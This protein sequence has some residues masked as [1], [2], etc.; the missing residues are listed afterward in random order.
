MNTIRMTGERL[1]SKIRDDLPSWVPRAAFDTYLRRH[2]GK[3]LMRLAQ[4]AAGAKKPSPTSAYLRSDRIW[5]HGTSTES[6]LEIGDTL[7]PKRGNYEACVW[8]TSSA[9]A[10]AIYAGWTAARGGDPIVFQIEIDP[11]ARIVLGDETSDAD[12]AVDLV[13]EHK[14]PMAAVLTWGT[15]RVKGVEA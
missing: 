9:K 11:S 8:V 13:G 5:Y 3:L 15:A 7:D 2:R 12:L 1:L 4:K 6:G 10:A 14:V